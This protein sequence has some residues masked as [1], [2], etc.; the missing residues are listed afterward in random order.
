MGLLELLWNWANIDLKVAQSHRIIM[1]NFY[2][3]H[4]QHCRCTASLMLSGL[5]RHVDILRRVKKS[6]E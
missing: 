5:A 2:I 3:M 1:H 4:Q 6:R